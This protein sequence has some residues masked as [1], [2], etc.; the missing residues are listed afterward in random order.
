MGLQS[1]GDAAGNRRG[2]VDVDRAHENPLATRPARQESTTYRLWRHHFDRLTVR[3][4]VGVIVLVLLPLGAGFWLLSKHQFDRTVARQ[5]RAAEEQCSLLE[6]ALRHQMLQRDRHLLSEVLQQV[7]TQPTIRTAMIVNHEGEVRASSEAGQVGARIER[8]SPTCWV[9]HSKSLSQRDRWV[10][11]DKG[12][13]QVLRT[14]LPIA[15]RSECHRCHPPGNP[16]NGMLI[17][18][19][20]LADLKAELDADALWFAG[21][22]VPLALILLGGVGFLVRRLILARIG[23]L[24]RT[25]RSIANGNL[26]ERAAVEGDDVISALASDFNDMTRTTSQLVAEVRSQEAQ[27]AS[28]MN[29]LSDGLV[30]LDRDSRVVASN[31]AFCRR[32]GL[33]PEEIRGLRCRDGMRA[34]LPCCTG[35]GECPAARCLATGR[36]QRAVFEM[37]GQDGE[38]GAV[39]EVYASPVFD[40]RGVVV[41]VVEVWRDISERVAEE[42]RL[43]EIERLVALGALASGFSHEINTPL[44]TMLTSAESMLGRIDE[45]R[46]DDSDPTPALRASAEMIRVQVLRC[47]RI[48]EQ[49]LRFSRGIPPS[50]EP[51]DLQ[52]VVAGVVALVE[53][54]AR[55]SRVSIR[56]ERNGPLPAVR[57]NSEVVQHVILNLLVNAIQSCESR[58]GSIAL[59]FEAGEGV[60]I[61]VRDDGCGIAP[62][63][64]AHLFEPFRTGKP[65][66]TGLGLFLSRSIMRRFGGDVRLRESAPGSGSCFEVLFATATE[67]SP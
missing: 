55:E 49:F 40:E 2:I 41:Q 18:D 16:F 10:V 36:L 30:V 39:E 32:V 3:F 24:A 19:T 46:P 59:A 29:N 31:S 23:R 5:R 21:G 8:A 35:G 9:C 52:S 6:V 50:I 54:T 17:L 1:N 34:P 20:S 60:R 13:E 27:L 4:A 7:G 37:P 26:D 25:A 33:L 42:Q 44:A 56:V 53:P 15:N 58:G 47:R 67:G 66:G 12:G 48:T 63:R 64:R 22:A 38:A 61:L 51:I 65:R 43:A 45:R 14:V 62:E 28:I 57:A 11:I